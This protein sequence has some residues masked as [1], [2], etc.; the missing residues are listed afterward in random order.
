[1]VIEQS[2]RPSPSMYEG[3]LYGGGIIFT[4]NAFIP[5]V[6]G[7]YLLRFELQLRTTS[8]TNVN[9]SH[10]CLVS[11][12]STS[13]IKKYQSCMVVRTPVRITARYH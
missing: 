12:N 1:M 7:K 5:I 2:P 8:T 10:S 9:L 11:L 13:Y 4:I 3:R 6:Y